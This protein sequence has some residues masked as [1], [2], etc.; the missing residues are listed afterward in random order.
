MAKENKVK[1]RWVDSYHNDS[2]TETFNN[3]KTLGAAKK[4]IKKRN[5][6]RIKGAHWF[7]PDGVVIKLI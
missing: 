1:I 7:G 2:Q 5:S 6:F 4:I 3:V